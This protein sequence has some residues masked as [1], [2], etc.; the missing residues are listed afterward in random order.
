MGVFTRRRQVDEFDVATDATRASSLTCLAARSKHRI[1]P[2]HHPDREAMMMPRR[3]MRGP[4][5]L[6]SGGDRPVTTDEGCYCATA[7]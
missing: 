3:W 5:P 6:L 2:S 7:S 4:L 1:R